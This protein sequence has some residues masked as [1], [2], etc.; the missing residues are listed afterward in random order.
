[1]PKPRVCGSSRPYRRFV[2]SVSPLKFSVSGTDFCM[3]KASSYDLMRAFKAGSSG[4][5]T[6]RSLLSRPTRSKPAFCSADVQ[7][8]FGLAVVE[9]VGRIDADRHGVVRR[10]EVVAVL[11][12]PVLALAHRDELRQVVVERAEPV[13]NPG[14]ERRKLAV[15]HVPAGV[16]LRLGAVVV[17]GGVHRA[18]DGDVVDATAEVREASR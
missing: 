8:A 10:A 7:L 13:V 4:Y 3:R 1:M 14:A 18:D 16:E 9:R 6:A 2:A 15:E 17:V 5:S 12:V 11:G